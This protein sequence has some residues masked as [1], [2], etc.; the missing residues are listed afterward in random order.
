VDLENALVAHESVK[1]AAVIAV[2][3]TKWVERP[4]AVIVLKEGCRVEDSELR[5]FLAQRFARWQL[6]DA[7]VFV[8]ELPHTATGKLLKSH[9]RKQ[10]E[11]WQWEAS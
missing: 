5:D 11:Q 4:L 1:E 6:P 10:F 2:P 9:L 3:H 8:D 7:F